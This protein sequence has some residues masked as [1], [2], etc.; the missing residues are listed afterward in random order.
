MRLSI[1]LKKKSRI[2]QQ[3][4]DSVQIKETRKFD[5]LGMWDAPVKTKTASDKIK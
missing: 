5:L 2:L 3:N 4:S 1:G